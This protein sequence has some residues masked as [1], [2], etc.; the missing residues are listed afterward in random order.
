MG[1]GA[2]G[3]AGGLEQRGWGLKGAK[4]LVSGGR[5]AGARG[6]WTFG[7]LLVRLFAMEGRKFPPLFYWTS[8][9]LAQLLKRKEGHRKLRKVWKIANSSF[10]RPL[11]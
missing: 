8:S 6:G 11:Y 4:G 10:I 5:G 7:C 9:P 1:D 2:W 3:V